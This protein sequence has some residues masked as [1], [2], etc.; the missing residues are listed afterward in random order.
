MIVQLG[1]RMRGRTM[2][3][4]RWRWRWMNSQHDSGAI[5]LD[6][7]RLGVCNVFSLTHKQGNYDA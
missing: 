7:L 3:R 1:S 4:T 5:I 2:S 6:C